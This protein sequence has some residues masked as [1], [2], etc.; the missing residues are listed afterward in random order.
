M[1]KIV[2]IFGIC[3]DDSFAIPGGGAP[4]ATRHTATAK[5]P[6]IEFLAVANYPTRVLRFRQRFRAAGGTDDVKAAHADNAW[7]FGVNSF[8]VWTSMEIQV[9]HSRQQFPIGRS[10]I[11]I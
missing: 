1:N 6:N 9:S 8:I 3:M 7:P 10:A 11:E 2:S 5:L 4:V